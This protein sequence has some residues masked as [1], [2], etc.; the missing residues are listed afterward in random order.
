MYNFNG[1]IKRRV[2]IKKNLRNK[3]NKIMYTVI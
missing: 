1:I 3:F 2:K